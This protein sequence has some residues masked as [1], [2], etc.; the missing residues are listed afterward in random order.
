MARGVYEVWDAEM[1]AR[2]AGMKRAGINAKDIAKRLGVT[3][4]SLRGKMHRIGAK[5]RL[6]GSSGKGHK[7]HGRY[8]LEIIDVRLQAEAELGTSMKEEE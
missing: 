7:G 5:C 2:A 4:A 3:T 6:D 1:I 8:V